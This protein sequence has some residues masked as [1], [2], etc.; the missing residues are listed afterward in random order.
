TIYFGSDNMFAYA[1]NASTGAQVWKSPKLPGLAMNSWWPVVN[2]S[3]VYFTVAINY[4]GKLMATE[5]DAMYATTNWPPDGT[6]Y[7]TISYPS[8]DHMSMTTTKMINYLNSN[9]G[10]RTLVVLNRSTGTEKTPYAPAL[11]GGMTGSLTRFPPIVDSK[12]RLYFRNHTFYDGAIP[13]GM[14]TAWDEGSINIQIVNNRETGGFGDYP[15]DEPGAVA[16]GGDVIY[17]SHCCSRFITSFD[18]SVRNTV[19]LNVGKFPV[20]SASADNDRQWRAIEWRISGYDSKFSQFFLSPILTDNGGGSTPS[21]GHADNNPPIPYNGKV[22][23]HR[24]NALIAMSPTGTG[25][26]KT[27]ASSPTQPVKITRSVSE[28][29]GKLQGEIQK[30]LAAGHL[31]PGTYTVGHQDASMHDIEPYFL[32]IF[33]NPSETYIILL[34]ALP[35]IPS[36]MQTQLRSYIQARWNENPATGVKHIGF[37]SG[38]VRENH[39]QLEYRNNPSGKQNGVTYINYYA[40]WIYAKE[41]GNASG[42]LSAMPSIQTPGTIGEGYPNKLNEVIAGFWGYCELYKMT[43]NTSTCNQQ[44]TLNNL[45]SQRAGNW[46][47]YPATNPLTGAGN[48]NYYTMPIAAN[49]MYI[50]P[51][52]AQALNSQG[53]AASTINEFENRF[54][55]WFVA[56]GTEMQGEGAMQPPQYYHGLFQAKATTALHLHLLQ[57][58]PHRQHQPQANPVMPMGTTKWTVLI[59]LPGLTITTSRQREQPMGISITAVR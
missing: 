5:R 19:L 39:V 24:G 45:I 38:A 11:T 59:T 20:V 6:P 31:R 41:F 52:F 8:G 50:E 13:G 25:Q 58:V 21:I 37:S 4:E 22:Y 28:L 40:A 33:H 32:D 57:P 16:A 47:I 42:I 3:S 17:H 2:G 15:I 27:A 1:L 43:N 29:Q 30:M 54:P 35:H 46:K 23:A 7:G 44:T 14:V 36:S 34:R 53:K 56:K 49:F 18:V 51:E 26:L 9:P 12:G 10:R 55:M 48:H